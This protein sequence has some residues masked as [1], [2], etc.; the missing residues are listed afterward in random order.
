MAEL[1]PL[2]QGIYAQ[3]AGNGR[4]S[5]LEVAR[6]LGVSEKTVR[7]RIR[8]L[9]ERDGMRVV[10]TIQQA[11]APSRLIVLIHSEAG[12]RFSVAER[13]AVQSEVDQVHLT[14]GA[15]ELIAEASFG[16][17]AEAIEW[18]VRNVESAPGVRSA[19]STHL[20]ETITPARQ[21]STDHLNDFDAKAEELDD[22]RDLFDL[23][24]DVAKLCLGTPRIVVGLTA[25][26]SSDASAPLFGS[27][28]RWRGLS[29]RYIEA[30]GGVRRSESVIIPNVIE[31]GQHVFVADAQTD[32]L[33]RGI[34]DLVV[35][36]GFHSF[37][38]VPVRSEGATHGTLNLY[39]DAIIPYSEHLVAQAQEVAD[40]IGKHLP[41]CAPAEAT[42]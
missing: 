41:R 31:R 3:L 17:D 42:V 13:L 35:S 10:A 25:S 5:N 29:A 4:M 32:P 27:G 40:L 22:V 19:Q 12:Q 38:A 11:P 33:F 37:L 6:H 30:L 20:I 8:R 16:S 36:E 9:I 15:Y 23:A 2:D 18:Y 7:Q 21:P 14:T 34:A 28:L 39:Y 26:D 24:C 1:D